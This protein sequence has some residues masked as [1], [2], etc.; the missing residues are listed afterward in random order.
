MLR[1]HLLGLGFANSTADT[2]LFTLRAGPDCAYVLVYVVDMLIT[3]SSAKIIQTCVSSLASR[4][5]IKDLRELWY[6]LGIEAT[7]TKSG[8]HLMQ[9]QYITE[10]LEK[11][12]MLHAKPASTPMSPTPKLS[13]NAGARL[14]NPTEYRQVVGSL[15]YLSLTRPDVAFEVNLL[16]QFMH[17]PTELH[18]QAVKRVMRYLAGTTTHRILI[19]RGSPLTLHVYSDADWTGDSDDFVSTNAYIVYIGNNP[20]S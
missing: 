12:K 15:Q 6:F 4:F 2:S 14:P 11:T 19:R 20:I 8:L 9:R 7:Q 17:Q 1:N 13:L 16:S 3:G 10:L 18:W 5:S